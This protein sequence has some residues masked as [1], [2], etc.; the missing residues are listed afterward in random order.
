[1]TALKTSIDYIGVLILLVLLLLFLLNF[2]Y[3]LSV[4]FEK[5]QN[6]WEVGFRLRFDMD[7]WKIRRVVLVNFKEIEEEIIDLTTFIN[8]IQ[9]LN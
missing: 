6:F 2:D 1:M 9:E 8:L 3:L 7:V 4:L 5:I